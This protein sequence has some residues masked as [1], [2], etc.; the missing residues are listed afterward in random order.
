MLILPIVAAILAATVSN[1]SDEEQILKRVHAYLLIQDPNAACDEA[2][3]ALK[4]YPE[5]SKLW[6]ADVQAL[7]KLGNEKAMVAA[8]NRYAQLDSKAYENRELLEQ[9]AWGVIANGGNS[10]S[11]LIRTVALVG[12]FFG[13]DAKGVDILCEHLRDSNS[14]VRAA[15]V[16][17][18]AQLLDAKLCDTV[19]SQLRDEKVWKVRLALIK[20]AGAMQI[21]QAK[22]YLTGIV[23]DS[24]STAEEQAAAIQA[25]VQLLDTVEREDVAKSAG[26]DRAGLR[27]LACHAVEHFALE[28]DL[29]YIMPLLQD[30]CSEVRAAA[31][32]TLGALRI[33]VFNGIPISKLAQ[34]MLN[35]PDT[36]VGMTAAW[37]LT[38][39]NPVAGQQAFKQWL[40]HDRSE[41]R[42][43]AA[44]GLKACGKYGF[45]LALEAFR[46][47][48]DPY[49]R[50]NLAIGLIGQRVAVDEACEE[51]K[52]GLATIKDR[53]M[54]QEKGFFRALAPSDL[55]YADAHDENPETVSQLVQL[56]ILNLLAIMKCSQAQEAIAAFLQQK[57]W[58]VTGLASALLLTEG[59]TEAITLV[60]NMM[61]HPAPKVRVQAA[62]VLALWGRG[63][64]AIA[65]L[66]RAYATADRELK[67]MIL[68]GIGR[69]GAVSTIPFL[70]ERLQEPAQSLRIIAASAL[71]QSLYH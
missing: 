63:E 21:V 28:R 46:Q 8:W 52:V 40:G 4:Q 19:L 5:S 38:L 44:A 45:P 37:V 70:V 53:M 23:A 51:L 31:L 10:S 43:Q 17:L 18:S 36:M 69:V 32:Q 34:G 1:A 58:G 13:Q 15:A 12:A 14:S 11:P 57:T 66:L 9:M 67:E 60:T 47:S 68:E 30:H 22:G 16:Q 7:A 6:E 55:R 27:L 64:D 24:N 50:M 48:H 20:A 65:V 62:L 59:D 56:D 61:S 25:L 33:P 26:S 71:L 42:I 3:A 54:W 35:D 41:I 39:L 49:V 2:A 29:D